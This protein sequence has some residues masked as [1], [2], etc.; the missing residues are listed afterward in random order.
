MDEITIMKQNKLKENKKQKRKSQEWKEKPGKLVP[1]A[2]A[3]D[4]DGTELFGYTVKPQ[5]HN[6][7]VMIDIYKEDKRNEI[8]DRLKSSRDDIIQGHHTEGIYVSRMCLIDTNDIIPQLD[9]CVVKKNDKGI[10]VEQ[11][12]TIE[13]VDLFTNDLVPF[14]VRI[15]IR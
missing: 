4:K 5:G 1:K 9:K 3:S 13:V 6:L 14:E 8:I 7:M 12:I 10:V 11:D 2:I 15:G